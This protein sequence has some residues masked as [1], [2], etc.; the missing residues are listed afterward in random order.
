[1]VNWDVDLSLEP[2]TTRRYARLL[3]R[4]VGSA[5]RGVFQIAS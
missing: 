5:V 2:R 4:Y 1:V 3:R